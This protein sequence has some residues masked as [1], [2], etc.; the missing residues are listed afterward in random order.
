MSPPLL[1]VITGPSGVGK[2]TLLAGMKERCA[3]RAYHFAVTATTRPKRPHEREGVD[4]HFLSPWQFD[5]ILARDGFLEHA[6]VYGH[7]YGVPKAQVR[8]ALAEDKDVLVRT[9]VQGASYIKSVCPQAVTIFLMPPSFQALEE[10]LRARASDDPQQIEMRLAIARREMAMAGQFDHTV[11]N[12][13]L[14][15][16][17]ARIEAIIAGEKAKP[18][19]QPPTL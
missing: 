13:R 15:D 18:G 10:R 11:V 8:Q 12:D 6:T 1:L 2:D 4:Y 16:A 7:R 17:V 5:H 14:E 19:R 9:D 3:G